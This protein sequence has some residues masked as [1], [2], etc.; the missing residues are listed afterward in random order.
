MSWPGAGLERGLAGVRLSH[1]L[2]GGALARLTGEFG[3]ALVG[4][5]RAV[6]GAVSGVLHPQ[7]A[8][9]GQLYVVPVGGQ[10]KVVSGRNITSLD[11]G[12]DET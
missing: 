2:A 6:A 9:V 5:D 4:E 7:E 8:T 3:L 12:G 10:D 11:V 1:I